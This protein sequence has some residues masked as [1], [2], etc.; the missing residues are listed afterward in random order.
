[1]MT[2][3]LTVFLSG[4]A[5]SP[6][7]ENTTMVNM[8]GVVGLYLC[9][10]FFSLLVLL[11]FLKGELQEVDTNKENK[12]EQV[13]IGGSNMRKGKRGNSCIFVNISN[14]NCNLRKRYP[15]SFCI[16]PS[17]RLF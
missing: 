17:R 10:Y 3:P 8:E 12:E 7:P 13:G 2:T 5:S 4:F 1:M 14:I 16:L 9:W 11:S 15:P 6:E